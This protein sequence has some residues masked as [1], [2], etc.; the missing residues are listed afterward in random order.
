MNPRRKGSRKTEYSFSLGVLRDYLKDALDNLASHGKGL[1]AEI[2]NGTLT[3]QKA[4]APVLS[5]SGMNAD[6]SLP[7]DK[8][9]MIVRSASN[10]WDSFDFR[11][12]I[13]VKNYEGLR[14]S[15]R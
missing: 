6:L 8:L 11:A 9:R 2:E 3:L 7:D 10:L 13:D 12:W 1:N 14:E 5:F 15:G 4:S